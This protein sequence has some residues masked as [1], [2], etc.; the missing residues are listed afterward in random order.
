MDRRGRPAGQGRE[1]RRPLT[2]STGT[3]ETENP[4]SDLVPVEHNPV[5]VKL[6]QARFALA[7]A[8]T[9]NEAKT[10]RDVAKAAADLLKQQR[11]GEEAVQNA[12]ELKLSAERRMGAFLA[13]TVNHAGSRG[14]DSGVKPTLPGD[15]SKAQSHRWQKVAALPEQVFDDYLAGCRKRHEEPPTAGCLRLER[16]QAQ[17]QKRQELAARSIELA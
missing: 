14:V 2:Q 3:E 6:E 16:V 9:L 13:E 17:E 1:A 12:L 5:L 11:L 15:L 8:R 7:E 10:I 4:M